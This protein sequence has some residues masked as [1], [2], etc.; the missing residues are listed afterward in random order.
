DIPGEGRRDIDIVAELFMRLR[1]LYQEEG[2]PGAEHF[3]NG[4]WNYADPN[5]PTADEPLKEINGRAR[6][7]LRDAEGNGV[8]RAGEQLASFGAMRDDGSTHGACLIYSGAY[9]PKRYHVQWRDDSD[10]SGMKVYGSWGF[11]WPATLRILYNLASADSLG[12]PWSEAKKYIF[13]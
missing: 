2:G 12:K 5:S 1:K 3:L 8:G 9:G 4:S 6:M 13:W 10:P 7:D 11:W